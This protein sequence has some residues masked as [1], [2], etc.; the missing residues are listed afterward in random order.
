MSAFTATTQEKKD[1]DKKARTMWGIAKVESSRIGKNKLT[2]NTLSDTP[3]DA[4]HNELLQRLALGTPNSCAAVRI[5][6]IGVLR[7]GGVASARQVLRGLVECSQPDGDGG[8]A[9]RQDGHQSAVRPGNPP[10]HAVPPRPKFSS[11]TPV[12]IRRGTPH[13]HAP[14][15]R[16]TTTAPSPVL[17]PR[18][19][20]ACCGTG[21]HCR[22]AEGWEDSSRALS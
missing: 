10:S 5:G 7:C 2:V 18:G 4:E 11:D 8:S 19:W 16:P 14:P 3:D 21:W 22:V 9:T 6:H 12:V 20:L 17:R 13:H 15:P 1:G